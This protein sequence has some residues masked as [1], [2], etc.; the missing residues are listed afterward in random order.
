M[1]GRLIRPPNVC[2]VTI[3]LHTTADPIVT[4]VV[5]GLVGGHE[6]IEAEV[7]RMGHVVA[8]EELR[9]PLRSELIRPVGAVRGPLA[10]PLPDKEFLHL[11]RVRSRRVFKN[12]AEVG[13]QEWHVIGL[14]DE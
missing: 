13:A 2:D 4:V 10:Q 12:T 9:N 3:D 7:V 11:S 8:L 6:S 14:L 5:V 1:V